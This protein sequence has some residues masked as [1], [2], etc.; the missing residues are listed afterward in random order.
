MFTVNGLQRG[1]AGGNGA[2]HHISRP[3]QHHARLITLVHTRHRTRNVGTQVA[4]WRRAW[5]EM[6]ARARSALHAV[7]SEGAPVVARRVPGHQVPVIAG[8][9]QPVRLHRAH[10]GLTAQVPVAEA[11]LQLIA[12]GRGQCG[13]HAGINGGADALHRHDGRTQ[14]V[15]AAAQAGGHHLLQFHQRAQRAFFHTTHR[16]R[17][18]NLQRNG[19]GQR[20]FVVQ[21]QRRQR[22]PRAKRVATRH[23]AARVNGVAQLTKSIYVTPQRAR[24][25]LQPLGQFRACP[26]ATGLQQ[27]Q[28]PKQAR[29]R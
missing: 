20:L 23:T 21:Q 17:C 3:V 2:Q 26:V 28:H 18:G 8:V 14:R 27:R 19:H 4:R 29:R 16:A 24:V 11:H 12:A 1:S 7:D 25:H 15:G 10:A 5:R 22:L 6:V 9:H 13:Q